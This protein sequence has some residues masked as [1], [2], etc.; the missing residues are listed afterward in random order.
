MSS[1]YSPYAPLFY[2][3]SPIRTQDMAIGENVFLSLSQPIAFI[4]LWDPHTHTPIPCGCHKMCTYYIHTFDRGTP[5]GGEP[6]SRKEEGKGEG[7]KEILRETREK[8]R[9]RGR[10]Y[11]LLGIDFKLEVNLFVIFTVN[12]FVRAVKKI[13]Y[14]TTYYPHTR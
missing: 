14:A 8:E 1:E 10:T 3:S 9:H 2:S 11:Y 6:N 5:Y 12:T 13:H 4:L 7:E